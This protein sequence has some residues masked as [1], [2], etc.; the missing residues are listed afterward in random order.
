MIGI[1]IVDVGRKIPKGVFSGYELE[2]IHDKG[3]VADQT[4]AGLFAAKEAYF[5]ALGTGVPISKLAQIE[6][7]HDSQGKPYY[8]LLGSPVKGAALSISHTSKTAVA[9]CI[10]Q[11]K[12]LGLS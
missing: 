9:V 8:A 11:E 6:I 2:Y 1:D 12:W 10:M 4:A 7:H 5:K 3:V